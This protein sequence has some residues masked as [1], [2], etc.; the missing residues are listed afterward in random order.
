MYYNIRKN[1][2][3]IKR[4]AGWLARAGFVGTAAPPKTGVEFPGKR[5]KIVTKLF[6]KHFGR[7]LFL[8]Y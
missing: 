3:K 8:S 5:P 4:G 6:A 7:F 2:C 1:N